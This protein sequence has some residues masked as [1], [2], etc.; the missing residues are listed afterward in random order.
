MTRRLRAALA[1]AASLILIWVLFLP[2][3]DPATER[4][5]LEF[6]PSALVMALAAGLA[7]LTLL[8]RRLGRAARW[9]LAA[10]VLAA[11]L[12]QAVAALVSS[13]LDRPL[14]LY[15]D[16]PHVPSLL[17]LFTQSIGPWKAAATLALAALAALALCAAVA[18]ALGAGQRAL[19]RRGA[20]VAVLGAA[21]AALALKE[22]KVLGVAPPKPQDAQ[23]LRQQVGLLRVDKRPQQRIDVAALK[24]RKVA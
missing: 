24:I 4:L 16:L 8:G 6:R 3:A 12:L 1:P 9:A 15:F 19:A 10:L 13:T 5:A 7:A 23:V 17:G 14:D 11:A 20:A 18:A 22:F 2:V 21:L